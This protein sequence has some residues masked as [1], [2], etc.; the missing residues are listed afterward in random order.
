MPFLFREWRKKK[1]SFG[2]TQRNPDREREQNT[3]YEEEEEVSSQ[4]DVW[5][6][7]K[8]NCVL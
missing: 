8:E 6:K 3:K 2:F 7:L 1:I 5:K 4:S